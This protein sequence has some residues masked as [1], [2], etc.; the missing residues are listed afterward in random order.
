LVVGVGRLLVGVG[1]VVVGLGL[2]RLD[3]VALGPVE[4]GAGR[5]GGLDCRSAL[6]LRPPDDRK[7]ETPSAVATPITGR[8]AVDV[9]TDELVVSAG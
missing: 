8:G 9:G 1:V 2:G 4:V 3:E 5:D 6:P 7:R